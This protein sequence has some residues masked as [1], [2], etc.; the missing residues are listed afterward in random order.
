MYLLLLIPDNLAASGLLPIAEKYLPYLV[1]FNKTT[2]KGRMISIITTGIGM[3]K[4]KPCPIKL[5]NG[6][7]CVL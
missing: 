1:K 4:K 7:K 6:I 2:K 3:F 5:N